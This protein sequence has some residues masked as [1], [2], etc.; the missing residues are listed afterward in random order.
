MNILMLKSR[1]LPLKRISDAEYVLDELHRQDT[2]LQFKEGDKVVQF[3]PEN[4]D[5]KEVF[6]YS[7]DHPSK[8][9]FQRISIE[10]SKRD[11]TTELYRL[12]KYFNQK[13]GGN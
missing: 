1:H 9:E 13:Y 10:Y 6:N 12:R 3:V 8:N 11:A 7:N 5:G 2:I 4:R